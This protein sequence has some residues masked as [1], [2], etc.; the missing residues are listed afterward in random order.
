MR[1]VWRGWIRFAL[2]RRPSGEHR[3]KHGAERVDIGGG[4]VRL[5]A[6][7]LRAGVVG[8]EPAIDRV[9]QI[10]GRVEQLGDAE[11]EQLRLARLV[12]QDV[13]GLDVAMDDEMPMGVGH[14]IAPRYLET[15]DGLRW[16]ARWQLLDH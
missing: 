6:T 11:V 4:G 8:R 15:H 7:L 3:V 14:R 10:A 2:L 5:P 1:A 12:D 13:R 9:R 16:K